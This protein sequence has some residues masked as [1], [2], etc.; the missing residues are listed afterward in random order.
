MTRIVLDDVKAFFESIVKNHG[1]NTFISVPKKY[2]GK[3]VVV[4]FLEDD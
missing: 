4:V 2:N 3:K 1:T